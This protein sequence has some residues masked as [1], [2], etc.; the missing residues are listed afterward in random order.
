MLILTVLIQTLHAIFSNFYKTISNC[1]SV[2][3]AAAS[4]PSLT[5][6]GTNFLS[7]CQISEVNRKIKTIIGENIKL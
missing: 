5:F 4:L 1:T 7:F 3:T 2:A 6:W